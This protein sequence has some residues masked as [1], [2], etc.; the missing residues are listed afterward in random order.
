MTQSRKMAEKANGK[1]L[2]LKGS[3]NWHVWKFTVKIGLRANDFAGYIDGSIMPPKKPS[4]K[5]SKADHAAYATALAAF[6]SKDYKAQEF[7]AS[8]MDEEPLGYL[9][10]CFTAKEIWDR[11][12]VFYEKDSDVNLQLLE[13]R[14]MNYSYDNKGM[15]K[16]VSGIEQLRS[17]INAKGGYVSETML[18][19]KLIMGLP[20]EYAH[21]SSAWDSV[22]SADRSLNTLISRLLIEEEKFKYYRGGDNGEGSAALIARGRNP[23]GNEFG[24]PRRSQGQRDSRLCNICK[25]PD[26]IA[27]DC[28]KKDAYENGECFNCGCTGHQAREC[29]T[30]KKNKFRYRKEGKRTE[31]DENSKD[32]DDRQGYTALAFMGN[33]DSSQ[34][35]WY[36]DSGASDHMTPYGE[37]LINYKPLNPAIKIKIGNGVYLEA[38]GIGDINVRTFNGREWKPGRIENVLHIPQITCNLFSVLKAN[39]KGL[40][41]ESDSDGCSFIRRDGEVMLTGVRK[42]NIHELQLEVEMEGREAFTAQ[43]HNIETLESWHQRL[44]HQGVTH[45]RQFLKRN[46]ILFIDQEFFCEACCIGKQHKQPFPLS[47]NRASYPGE[48]LHAD[49]CGKFNTPS[50]GKAT[51]RER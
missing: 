46:E 38:I 28:E 14:L 39:D 45:V 3:S 19:T 1:P 29:P 27:D 42:R 43:A 13:Q 50:L 31:K 33:S 12:C 26:H 35:S 6:E 24:N 5:A 11:L 2:K 44:A 47:E 16:Y 9:T 36:A 48:V 15:A 49:V 32:R 37:W 23:R 8:R 10:D 30:K 4:S 17:Q 22:P 40:K 7:L 51:S 18:M 25:S 21:F 34:L 20:Q 41:F